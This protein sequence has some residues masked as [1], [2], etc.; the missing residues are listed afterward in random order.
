M[1]G[2]EARPGVCLLGHHELDYPRNRSVR[3]A[4]EAGGF[5]V[6]ECRS[7]APF[8]FRHLILAA[9]LLSKGRGCGWVFVTEGGHRLVP[10]AKLAARLSGKRLA[11]DPFTSRYNTRIED[12]RL[13]DPRSLEALLC[14]WQDWSSTHCADLLFF[15]TFEH[16]E[17][18]RGRYGFSAPWAVLPVGVDEKVFRPAPPGAPP[19]RP[20]GDPFR[21]LFY[22]T[23]I[24]LQGVEHVVEAAARLAREGIE[25][26]LVG[27]GQT[28]AEV[29]ARA[30]AVG[31]PPSAFA[32]PV[33]PEELGRMLHRTEI[34]LGIFGDTVK[35]ASVVPNKVVQAAAAGRPLVT[36]D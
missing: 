4:L 3:E 15:D 25:V 2:T 24:P 14:R 33:P 5:R 27:R 13:H 19:A 32:E 22:G 21:V 17:Y 26:T 11:F 10:F 29:R 1:P 31:L 6:V 28:Y 20:S 34:A 30:D 7:T 9:K 16:M 8:P 18:F 35:A 23:Y 36:R 12:R